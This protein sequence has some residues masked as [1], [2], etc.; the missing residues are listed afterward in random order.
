MNELRIS[1][2]TIECTRSNYVVRPIQD[3]EAQAN[4]GELVLL[5]GP[6][7][8][9]KTALLSCMAG[10]LTPARGT[11][12]LDATEVTS[13]EGASLTDFRRSA[14]GTVVQG[15]KPA[16]GLSVLENVIAPLRL[17]GISQRRARRR[18]EELLERVGLS[19]RIDH[20]LEQLSDGQQKRASIA[21]ALVHD[22][23]LIIADEPTAHLDYIQTEEVLQLLR[24]IAAPGRLVVLATHDGRFRPLADR[25]IDL[26]PQSAAPDA[27][28]H[29]LSLAAGEVLFRQGDDPDLVYVVER[30]QIEVYRERADGSEEL[31]SIFGRGDHF[32]ELGSLLSLPRSASAR[33]TETTVLTSYG[34]QAFRAW[35]SAASGN[36]LPQGE[37]EP[38]VVG[39]PGR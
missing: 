33:A 5:L 9:G 12:R 10:L 39:S 20:L 3:L 4:D 21:R 32:G 14:V 18:S 11:I 36:G 1:E 2:L 7:G 15:F 6:S 23:P 37:P 31:R 19:D 13:L 22:P 28:P 26:T 27:A 38:P 35:Q 8:S 30:G 24:E 34:V 25:V 17:A 16:E 29:I